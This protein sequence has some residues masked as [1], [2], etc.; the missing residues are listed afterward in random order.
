MFLSLMNYWIKRRSYRLSGN[1]GASEGPHLHFEFRMK[2][3][4]V[5]INAFDMMHLKILLKPII[6][7]LY[8]Y[9]LDSK[10]Q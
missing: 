8:V 9:P 6:S 5:I 3:E 1:T 2:T 7:G 10:H 4:F